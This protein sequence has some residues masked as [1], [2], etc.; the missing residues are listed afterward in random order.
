MI[1]LTRL[2]GREVVMN[3]DLIVTVERTPDTVVTL[4]TGDRIM[5]R[6]SVSQVV[7]EAI[8]YRRKIL[9]GPPVVE[10]EQVSPETAERRD[11]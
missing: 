10:G 11:G 9:Q 4:T 5:V 2:D 6:E 7:Q 1:L 3:C 8:A